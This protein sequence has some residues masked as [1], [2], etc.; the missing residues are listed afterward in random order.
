MKI[1][2]N[3][4]SSEYIIHDFKNQYE[5]VLLKNVINLNQIF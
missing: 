2:D 4:L 5:L 1:I 3:I